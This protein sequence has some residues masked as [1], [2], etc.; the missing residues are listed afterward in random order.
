M[1]AGRCPFG[2]AC[3]ELAWIDPTR[4]D[5]DMIAKEWGWRGCG[6]D[7]ASKEMTVHKVEGGGL[8]GVTSEL[9]SLVLCS[10]WTGVG[11]SYKKTAARAREC[12][13]SGRRR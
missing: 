6:D 9:A 11:Q 10:S 8:R 2:L 1:K 7:N 5:Q 3:L 12:D 13:G 4:R